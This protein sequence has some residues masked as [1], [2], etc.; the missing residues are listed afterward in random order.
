M[1]NAEKK[2]N[3]RKLTGQQSPN[4]EEMDRH[5]MHY[6]VNDYPFFQYCKGVTFLEE[7]FNKK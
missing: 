5:L 2:I 4:Q 7:S 6:K 3:S 1:E